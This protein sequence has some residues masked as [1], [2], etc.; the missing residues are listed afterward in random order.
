MRQTQSPI[1]CIQIIG[2]LRVEAAYRSTYL[3][4]LNSCIENNYCLVYILHIIL[5]RI[6]HDTISCLD[7]TIASS[8]YETTTVKTDITSTVI[9]VSIPVGCHSVSSCFFVRY[10]LVLQLLLTVHGCYIRT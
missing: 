2:E 9:S 1:I 6:M 8:I 4:C 5:Y 7:E 3:F 10:H